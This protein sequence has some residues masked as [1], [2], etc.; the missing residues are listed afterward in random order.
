MRDRQI[1]GC[2][3][4]REVLSLDGLDH[5]LCVAPHPDDEVLGPG[6]LMA[7]LADLGRRVG[8]VVLTRGE[9]STPE[10]SGPI[11]E[12]RRDESRRAARVLGVPGPLF[13]RWS[14]R[15]LIYG[16]AL[17]ADLR[18]VV[19]EFRAQVLL[20][21]ALSEPHPDHQVAALVGMAVAQRCET[22]HTVLFYEVGAPMHPNAIV[23]ITAVAERKWRAIA[24]FE[25]Q[26][27]LQPYDSQARAMSVLRAFGMPEGCS[28][29]E[30]LFRVDAAA[31]RA[32]GPAAAL[33]LWPLVRARSGLANAPGE[34]PLVSVLVRS[35]DRPQLTEAI[36]SIAVQTWPNIEVVVLNATGR[37]HAPVVGAPEG[38]FLRLVE[39]GEAEGGARRAC[40]RAAAANLALQAAT[41]E[42]ALFL[43]DDDLIQPNHL[44]RLVGAL[45]GRPGA[46]AA[47]AGVRVEGPGGI[48][49]RDYDLP[50]SPERLAGINFLPIHAVL[51]RLPPV[52]DAALR[53][54]ESLAVLED[55][56]FWCEL[57][58]LGEFIHCPG[59]SA[60]YRQAL[61]DSGVGRPG[62]DNHWERWHRRV[63]ERGLAS[64]SVEEWARV[65][66]WHAIELD[67]LQAQEDA[68]V[69]QA[70]HASADLARCENRRVELEHDVARLHGELDRM[71]ASRSWRLT[72][73]LRV[74][75]GWLRGRS[76]SA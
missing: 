30:A 37:T 75:T 18:A 40:G 53:F 3:Y 66:A 35:M 44:E 9:S 36:A 49:L 13:L 56:A 41:G 4:P 67:R 32:R 12:C 72:H 47:Y 38:M 60:L 55:W 25:S 26:L 27:A 2:Y 17:I 50:W 64:A 76:P 74:L 28:A 1:E 8:S 68:L 22:V 20:L 58:R 16:E 6:G 39:P 46:V 33:P 21:P 24:Q 11:A 62:H 61:G 70:A 45:M 63:L 73:P 5:V 65:L 69:A 43:D 23:D 15:G 34:L 14:D 31:L 59:V 19:E 10:A 42:Y 57:A 71:R 51:F 29:A 54:D 7:R 48:L 52:R